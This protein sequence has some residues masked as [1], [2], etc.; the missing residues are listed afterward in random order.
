M[1]EAE[2]T[3]S[4]LDDRKI[5][6]LFFERSEQA[7]VELSNK[8]GSVCTKVAFNILNNKQDN[9]ECV[10]DAYLGTWNTVPPQNPNPLLSYVCR[11][12][13]NLAIKRY[14]A[15]TAAKRN[16]IYDVALDELENC[17]PSFA[18]VEY[19]FSAMET[20][21]MI[22]AFLETLDQKNRIMFVRRYWHSDSIDDLAKLFYTSNHNISVRLSRTREKLKKYLIKEGVT[23]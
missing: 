21:R 22:D 20:A 17:F 2:R 18:S 7:I 6:E 4:S 5:I 23:L 12:V 9:E 3:V 19:E 10:N 16:S 11:I 13:R 15:N 14:H 8:Y 1:F